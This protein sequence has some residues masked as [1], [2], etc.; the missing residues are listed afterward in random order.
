MFIYRT[1]PQCTGPLGRG[2][3]ERRP[4]ETIRPTKNKVSFSP[5]ESSGRRNYCYYTTRRENYSNNYRT[6]AYTHTHTHIR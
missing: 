3:L 2:E 6:Y 1:N 5:V 4:I